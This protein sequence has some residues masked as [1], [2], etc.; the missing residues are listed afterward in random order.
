MAVLEEVLPLLL[1]LAVIKTI[2]KIVRQ[3]AW[4]TVQCELRFLS[5]ALLFTINCVKPICNFILHAMSFLDCYG[6]CC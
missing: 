3:H 4:G 6:I 2:L 1:L 5:T